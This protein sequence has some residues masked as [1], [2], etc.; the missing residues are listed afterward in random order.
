MEQNSHKCYMVYLGETPYGLAYQLQQNLHHLRGDLKIEDIL[1]ILQHPTTITIGKSGKQHNILTNNSRLGSAHIEV[2]QVDRGGD[3]TIHNPGQLVIYPIIDLSRYFKD[4]PRFVYELEETLILTLADYGLSG[5]RKHSFPGVWI[6]AEKIAAIGL[7]LSRWITMHGLAL[8]V[9]NDLTVF[10]NINP[11]GIKNCA[12][13]S[14]AV[15]LGSSITMETLIPRVIHHFEKRF[16][17]S[18][19]PLPDSLHTHY[20]RG[21]NSISEAAK[22]STRLREEEG[23]L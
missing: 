5:S 16:G 23:V 13:T 14:M 10:Q 3:V 8:N 2:Y 1:L 7:R 17:V 15:Q 9:N 22:H 11:C 19:E 20:L 12:V 21:L 4:V 6:G 18:I